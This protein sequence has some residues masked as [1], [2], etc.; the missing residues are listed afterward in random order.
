MMPLPGSFLLPPSGETLSSLP[1][2]SLGFTSTL[3][4]LEITPAVPFCLLHHLQAPGGRFHCVLGTGLFSIPHPRAS[5]AANP[6]H[7]E[8]LWEC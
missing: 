3:L 1:L 2:C 8:R 4:A 7:T 5:P 6:L